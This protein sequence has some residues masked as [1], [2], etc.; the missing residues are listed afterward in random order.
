MIRRRRRKRRRRTRSRR[1]RRSRQKRRNNSGFKVLNLSD[2]YCRLFLLMRVMNPDGQTDRRVS[3]E[4][5]QQLVPSSAVTNG[6]NERSTGSGTPFIAQTCCC[7]IVATDGTCYR[8]CVL[9]KSDNSYV[10]SLTSI[11]EK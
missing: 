1:R 9:T 3:H 2:E 8:S 7:Q 10:T 4:E 11:S 5:E 6:D